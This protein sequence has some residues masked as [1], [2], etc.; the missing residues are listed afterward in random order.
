MIKN[1]NLILQYHS[2]DLYRRVARKKAPHPSSLAYTIQKFKLKAHQPL[3][4][5]PAHGVP[6]N[7]QR[8]PKWRPCHVKDYS[9]KGPNHSARLFIVPYVPLVRI[10][11]IICLFENY[12]I[13]LMKLLMQLKSR[14]SEVIALSFLLT[15]QRH[16]ILN[17]GLVLDSAVNYDGKSH[18][19]SFKLTARN[20]ALLKHMGQ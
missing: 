8:R 15:N 13:L 6:Q 16:S 10:F 20:L 7:F 3:Q 14:K 4:S 19:I 11:S 17:E 18:I 12:F 5:N 2:W 9:G 1:E